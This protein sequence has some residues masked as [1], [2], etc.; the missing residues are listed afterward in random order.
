MDL[1]REK[2]HGLVSSDRLKKYSIAKKL[3]G[4]EILV[5]YPI[6]GPDSDF[7]CTS[8]QNPRFS[9]NQLPTLKRSIPETFESCTFRLQT[10]SDRLSKFRIFPP[11]SF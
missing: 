4:F 11:K 2:P 9:V 3:G 1:E 8:K 5:I 7:V 10:F 6:F